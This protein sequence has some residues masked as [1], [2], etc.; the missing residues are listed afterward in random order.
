[1]KKTIGFLIFVIML[2]NAV[3][4]QA[5]N[6]PS[7][8]SDEQAH[9]IVL[10]G[11]PDDVKKLIQSGYDVN[12]VYQCNTLL[13]VAVKSAVY[14]RNANKHPTYA[15]EKIKLLTKAGAN[16]NKVSCIGISMPALHWAVALPS[17]IPDM[18]RDVNIAI[19]EKIKSEN[20]IFQELFLNRAEKLLLKKERKSE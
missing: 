3:S 14:S 15:L 19:D 17:L 11:T 18:E 16:I 7:Q 1:M 5:Q 8:I 2:L 10:T 13:N 12:K 6:T 20:V 9:E 4:L